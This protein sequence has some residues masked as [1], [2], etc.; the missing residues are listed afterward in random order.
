M[1]FCHHPHI[2]E[3]HRCP[4]GYRDHL[5]IIVGLESLSTFYRSNL[6]LPVIFFVLLTLSPCQPVYLKCPCLC[7]SVHLS[8]SPF[9]SVSSPISLFL[10]LSLSLRFLLSLFLSVFSS[11]LSHSDIGN[12]KLLLMLCLF[13]FS[14]FILSHPL[15]LSIH[16]SPCLCLSVFLTLN[17]DTRRFADALSF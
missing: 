1:S 7:L 14:S 9:L 10:S 2:T 3:L 8:P 17:F 16:L 11:S 13:F 5:I 4:L 6:L 15:S 12:L